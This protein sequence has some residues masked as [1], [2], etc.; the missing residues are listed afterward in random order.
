MA[1]SKQAGICLPIFMCQALLM[2]KHQAQ[3]GRK[4]EWKYSG[5][6]ACLGCPCAGTPPSLCWCRIINTSKSL[7]HIRPCPHKSWVPSCACP[8]F[9]HFEAG[10]PH[11]FWGFVPIAISRLRSHTMVLSFSRM[12]HWRHLA[13]LD[14]LDGPG[15]SFI[16]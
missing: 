10:F 14:V 1:E 13:W 3:R 5:R 11:I 4:N 8:V 12:D 9:L 2:L 16:R 6:A 15:K 7:P